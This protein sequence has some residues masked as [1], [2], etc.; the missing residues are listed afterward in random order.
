MGPKERAPNTQGKGLIS[1]EKLGIGLR[2]LCDD[3]FAKV[4]TTALQMDGLDLHV[5]NKI[6]RKEKGEKKKEEQIHK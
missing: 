3:M 1:R 5:T 6:K 4:Q 2:H